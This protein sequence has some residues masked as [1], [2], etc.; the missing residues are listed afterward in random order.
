MLRLE[1][2]LLVVRTHD[3]LE[4]VHHVSYLDLTRP[5]DDQLLDEKS[6]LHNVPKDPSPVLLSMSEP[7]DIS[8]GDRSLF[9]Q[10]ARRT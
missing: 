1:V 2:L 6:T 5:M 9:S 10:I 8:M 4:S 3:D 7:D